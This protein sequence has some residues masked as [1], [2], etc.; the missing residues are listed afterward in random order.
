MVQTAHF[1][2]HLEVNA[3]KIYKNYETVIYTKDSLYNSVAANWLWIDWT[4]KSEI[5]W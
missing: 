3:V 5:L 2:S 1:R 4:S